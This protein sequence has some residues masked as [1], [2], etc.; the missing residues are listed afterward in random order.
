MAKKK[1]SKK[2]VAKK[3]VDKKPQIK[4]NAKKVKVAV[5]KEQTRLQKVRAF[6][7]AQAEH[8]NGMFPRG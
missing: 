8:F 6:A 1:V 5:K 3:K 7:A 4:E 2:K